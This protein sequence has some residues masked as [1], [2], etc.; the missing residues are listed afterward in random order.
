VDVA[1]PHRVGMLLWRQRLTGARPEGVRIDHMQ[2]L[3][4]RARSQADP[5]HGV[6]EHALDALAALPSS[7]LFAMLS[8]RTRLTVSAVSAP[9]PPTALRAVV[10][11]G[12]SICGV[13]TCTG[14]GAAQM[15]VMY[16]ESITQADNVDFMRMLK[17]LGLLWAG[18]YAP[19]LV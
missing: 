4:G 16:L 2:L 9:P 11:C 12:S 5:H 15:L 7:F 17:G 3:N 1:L 14:V 6:F 18:W 8:V 10:P 13:I 19:T